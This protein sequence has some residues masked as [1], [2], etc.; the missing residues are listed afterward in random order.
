MRLHVQRSKKVDEI[1]N[2][3]QAAADVVDDLNMTDQFDD[4]DTEEDTDL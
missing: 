4:E 3:I 2:K 1:T